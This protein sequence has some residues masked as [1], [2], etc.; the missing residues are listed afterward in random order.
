MDYSTIWRLLGGPEG[1]GY[2]RLYFVSDLLL[3][4]GCAFIMILCTALASFAVAHSL[5]L[6][7]PCWV[8]AV[9]T[10]T[11]LG[12]SYCFLRGSVP[13]DPVYGRDPIFDPIW[14]GASVGMALG[15]GFL[16]D[17]TEREQERLD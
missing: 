8:L 10:A 12:I 7:S 11:A 1:E 6:H 9:F 5:K 3:R 16:L 13:Y 17:A 2:E 15:T 4:S 14:L